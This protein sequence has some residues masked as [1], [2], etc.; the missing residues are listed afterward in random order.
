MSDIGGILFAAFLILVLP[1]LLLLRSRHLRTKAKEEFELRWSEL[2]QRVYSLERAVEKLRS[3]ERSQEA[4]SQ[5]LVVGAVLT[6]AS[7][8]TSLHQE[9]PEQQ[10]RSA[11]TLAT[12]EPKTP[13]QTTTDLIAAFAAQSAETSEAVFE[14]QEPPATSPGGYSYA[15]SSHQAPPAFDVL[16]DQQPSW[17][18]RL[19]GGFA[20]E[21]A[22]GTNW[23]NKI[24]IVIL[25]FGIAFFLAYELRELGPVGKILVGFVV[26]AALLGSGLFLERRPGYSILGRAGIGGGWALAFFTTYAMHHVE[27]ARVLSSQGADLVLMGIVASGMVVHSLRYRSQAVTGLTFLLA[28]SAVTISHV[29]VYSLSAGI[30][31]SAAIIIVTLRMRWYELE[32]LGILAAYLNHFYWLWHIIEPMHGHK[33]AFAEFIPSSAILLCYWVIYRASYIVRKTETHEQELLAT[34]AALLN[35]FGLLGLFKY[36]SIHPEWAFWALLVLGFAEVSMALFARPRRRVA[37]SVLASIGVTLLFAAVPFRFAAMNVT[38]LWMAAAEALLLVGIK[39]NERVFRRLAFAGV[40]AAV[41]QMFGI[42]TARIIGMRIDGAMPGRVLPV[43]FALVCSAVIVYANAHFVVRRWSDQFDSLDNRIFRLLTYAAAALAI[44]G[45]WIAFPGAETA[46]AWAVAALILA[47]SSNKLQSAD[48]EIQA[49][50][51]AAFAFVRAISVNFET[52]ALWGHVSQRLVTVALCALALYLGSRTRPNYEIAERFQFPRVYTWLAS[53]LVATLIWFELNTVGIAPAWALFGL[54]LIELGISRASY[55][56]KAQ[57]Y[58]ALA[59]SV[60]R[61]FIANLA[62]SGQPGEVSPRLYS[63]IP[64]ILILFSVYYRLT[65]DTVDDSSLDMRYQLP[66]ACAWAGLACFAALVRFELQPDWVIVAWVALVPVLMAI[67]WRSRRFL[68]LGQAIVMAVFAV[69]RGCMHNLYARSVFPAPFLYSRKLC[70]GVTCS[71]LFLSLML[72]YKLVGAYPATTSESK[73]KRATTA[74]LQ[75][76]EQVL[77]FSGFV[78]MISLLGAETSRGLLTISWSLLGV[79]TFLFALSVGERSFRLAGLGLLLLGVGK[80]AV[81]DVWSLGA[82]D[83]YLTFISMGT[84]LLLVSFLYTRFREAIRQYL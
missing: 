61:V 71:V 3:E 77:F 48:L 7:V 19:K 22:L 63:T 78:L 60:S 47:V 76:P 1:W 9:A 17:F 69:A 38:I 45:L 83:R 16:E 79:I 36:Q 43:G 39:T 80:I 14:E 31:L 66:N 37:F 34:A 21:E 23:L 18:E 81:V 74:C 41:V 32:I 27:A 35:T 58:I 20:L 28:F 70:V 12:S 73:W 44:T 40:V 46:A 11:G 75:H 2:T 8:E 65:T 15:A 25:V 51:I 52:T 84:A 64:I 59:A 33:H 6:D 62:A 82:R 53:V 49:D 54:I 57:G 24:G 30:V 26:S 29:T 13:R 4:R 42:D 50:T 10:P 68:F 72:A 56:W 5:K 67:A 55:H